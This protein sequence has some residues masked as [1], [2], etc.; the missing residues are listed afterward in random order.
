MIGSPSESKVSSSKHEPDEETES[1]SSIP[2]AHKEY[3]KLLRQLDEWSK[4]GYSQ[5]TEQPASSAT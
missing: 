3:E 4:L 1:Q 5:P 2:P